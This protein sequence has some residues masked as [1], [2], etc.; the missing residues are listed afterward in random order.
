VKFSY[1]FPFEFIKYLIVNSFTFS[2]GI[3]TI[4]THIHVNLNEWLNIILFKII[5]GV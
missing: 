3:F 1:Y 2:K 5:V 4:F